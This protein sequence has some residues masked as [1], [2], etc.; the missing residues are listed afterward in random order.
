MCYRVLCLH[1]MQSCFYF[2]GPI[3]FRNRVL[4]RAPRAKSA[5]IALQNPT[6][7]SKIQT[8]HLASRTESYTC[9]LPGGIAA[10]FSIGSSNVTQ[11]A[12]RRLFR[13]APLA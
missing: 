2:R 10:R 5:K 13:Q 12:M 7:F 4:N 11:L 8:P 6:I 3:P 1:P 9:K